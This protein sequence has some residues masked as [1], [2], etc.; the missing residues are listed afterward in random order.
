PDKGGMG[1]KSAFKEYFK[2]S[3]EISTLRNITKANMSDWQQKMNSPEKAKLKT[4]L[5]QNNVD[6]TSPTAVQN[7]YQGRRQAA[8]QLLVSMFKSVE[9]ELSKKVG[10]P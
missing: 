8:M 3:K 9:A 7:F 10:R 2:T 6:T 1:M 4:F 5:E